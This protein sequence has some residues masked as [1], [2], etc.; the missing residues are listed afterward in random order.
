LQVNIAELAGPRLP[1]ISLVVMGYGAM[2][3]ALIH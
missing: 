3:L 1:L 2:I